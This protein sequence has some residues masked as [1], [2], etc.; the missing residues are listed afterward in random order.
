MPMA[1]INKNIE[2]YKTQQVQ[3]KK[4][5]IDAKCCN[6]IFIIAEFYTEN[7]A[8]LKSN[9][10]TIFRKEPKTQT[11]NC[12]HMFDEIGLIQISHPD[13]ACKTLSEFEDKITEDAIECEAQEV[14]D[15]N[16]EDKTATIICN[17]DFIDK[18][19]GDLLKR[20]YVI[21]NSE[22]LFI[23][24]STISITDDERKH[25]DS[26]VKRITQLDGFDKI[27]DNLETE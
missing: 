20:G 9:L 2:K 24:H 5:V 26:F 13:T 17:P 25:Y 15:V 3:L 21:D 18:V 12:R 22:G 14:D 8:L 10:N 4:H 6:K 1:T 16:F 7:L 27:F 11:A 23:P 19:K